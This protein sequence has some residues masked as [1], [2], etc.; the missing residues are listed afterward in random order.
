MVVEESRSQVCA[1][2]IEVTRNQNLD[3]FSSAVVSRY[4]ELIE[5]ERCELSSVEAHDFKDKRS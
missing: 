4:Q 2:S 1:I 3:Q 5:A